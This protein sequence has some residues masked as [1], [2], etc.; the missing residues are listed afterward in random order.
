[1]FILC[2][3]I[4]CSQFRGEGKKL[5]KAKENIPFSMVWQFSISS[6]ADVVDFFQSTL[7]TGQYLSFGISPIPH[8]GIFFA[9]LVCINKYGGRLH[10]FLHLLPVLQEASV[11]VQNAAFFVQ[12]ARE[13]TMQLNLFCFIQCNAG[14]E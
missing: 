6:L 2:T 13:N 8:P 1:M 9:F 3:N 4:L 7:A 5:S 11:F 14:S 10:A 12:V